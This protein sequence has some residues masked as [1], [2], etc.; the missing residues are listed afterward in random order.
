LPWVKGLV[1]EGGFI[2]SVKCKVCSLIEISWWI[3]MIILAIVQ[4]CIWNFIN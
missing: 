1:N 4:K 3:C 2:Q